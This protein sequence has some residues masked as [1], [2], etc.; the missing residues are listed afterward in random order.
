MEKACPAAFRHHHDTARCTQPQWRC[1]CRCDTKPTP[2]II[3]QDPGYDSATQVVVPASEP[4]A[5]PDW[6]RSRLYS[7]LSFTASVLCLGYTRPTL[8]S[9]TQDPSRC[10]VS[11]RLV[12][13]FVGYMLC[14]ASL[15]V[16]SRCRMY[17]LVSIKNMHMS[18]CFAALLT[19]TRC[20]FE[21]TSGGIR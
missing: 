7:Q 2:K 17:M 4:K 15:V 12:R 6:R 19:S 5:C 14:Y 9:V 18:H 13:L 11:D 8:L 16:R 3:Q 1:T 21:T 10:I 20:G